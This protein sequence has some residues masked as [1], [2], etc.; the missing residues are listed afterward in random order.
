MELE[1]VELYAHLYDK[2][3]AL[4]KWHDTSKCLVLLYTST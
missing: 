3:A 4:L 1:P 2:P